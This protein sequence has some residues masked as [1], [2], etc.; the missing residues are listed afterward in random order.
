MIKKN[1]PLKTIKI[2]KERKIGHK[3][4]VYIIAEAGINHNGS[5]SNALLMIE[6]AA[7]CGADAI[8]FQLFDVN[9]LATKG[10][11]L[12]PYQNTENIII[13]S[14]ID[15]LKKYQF[16][17][18]TFLMLQKK[19]KECKIDFLASAFDNQSQEFL[20]DLKIPILKIA[21]GEITNT[22]LT[23]AAAKSQ[24]PTIIST[25]MATLVEIEDCINKF[26]KHNNKIIVLH[27]VSMYPAPIKD[28]NLKFIKNLKKKFNTIVGFSDHSLGITAAITAVALGAKVIEKHF[29]LNKKWPG[30]DHQASLDTKE[31][32]QLVTSIRECEASLG[33]NKKIITEEEESTKKIV[34]KGLYAKHNIEIGK[35]IE[36]SDISI[37]RPASEISP[38]NMVK[39]IG[40]KL[41]KKLIK[42]CPFIK[43]NIE[44]F[45]D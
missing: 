15:L 38:N 33:I 8:K 34:R 30:P 42:G 41:N 27:C 32:S 19:A 39:I 29:T 40:K 20:I 11:P 24:L 16:N 28:L 43:V 37:L 26:V 17:K 13:K 12:A 2:N 36:K 45:Y 10:A 5:V 23:E 7:K 25:G 35:K 6:V 4:E 9:S 44:G 18:K 22:S 3:S 21:S 14:Q 31:L 1:I